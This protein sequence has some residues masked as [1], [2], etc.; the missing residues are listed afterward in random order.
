MLPSSSSLPI[1]VADSYPAPAEHARVLS[2][3]GQAEELLVHYQHAFAT[4][5]RLTSQLRSISSHIE[6]YLAFEKTRIAPI[7]K[8]PHDL[9]GKIFETAA[10]RDYWPVLRRSPDTVRLSHVCKEWRF[11]SLHHPKLWSFLVI[12]IGYR[13]IW[14]S[15][16]IRTFLTRSVVA[17]LSIH[18]EVR[19]VIEDQEED[20]LT[21]E[22]LSLLTPHLN[23]VSSVSVPTWM[24]WH[25]LAKAQ[26]TALNCLILEDRADNG[27][28]PESESLTFSGDLFSSCSNF[29]QLKVSPRVKFSPPFSA[30]FWKLL[31]EL[32]TSGTA[33]T[34]HLLPE[35]RALRILILHNWQETAGAPLPLEPITLPIHTLQC[36]VEPGIR[37]LILPNL[38]ELRIWLNHG[39]LS[40][41][42]RNSQ[43]PLEPVRALILRSHCDIRSGF[44]F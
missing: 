26:F 44:P 19:A 36:S 7:R 9:L 8:L 39:S 32:E 1:Y 29:R 30:P 14:I 28:D 11:V 15:E 22:V 18:V 12:P 38:N 10:E 6:T 25:G 42:N 20:Y 23:R 4:A 16:R 35:L 34:F 33:S 3:I 5:D 17:P 31:V 41:G 27:S 2:S 37:S 24:A 40:T 43:L 21:S 13:Q